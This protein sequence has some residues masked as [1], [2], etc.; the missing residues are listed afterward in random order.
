ML[1]SFDACFVCFHHSKEND[2]FIS[3]DFLSHLS[4]N[5]FFINTSRGENVDELCF[6][7]LIESGHFS[8]VAIDVVSKEQKLQVS[9]NNLIKAIV[10]HKNGIVTP[11]IAGSTMESESLAFE[12]VAKKMLEL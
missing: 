2:K 9:N 11:H 7:R 5:S 6:T 4:K 8:G 10:K 1:S 3:D 12:L